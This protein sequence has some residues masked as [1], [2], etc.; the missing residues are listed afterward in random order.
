MTLPTASCDS[1]PQ[2][3]KYRGH[4]AGLDALRGSAVLGVVVCHAYNSTTDWTHWHGLAA[5][6][7]AITLLGHLGVHLFFVLSGFL[8]TGLLLDGRARGQLPGEGESSVRRASRFYGRRA[9]RILPAYLLMLAVLLSAH[10]VNGHFVLASLFFVVNLGRLVGAQL[11]QYSVVWSLAVEE[12][13]YLLWPWLAWRVSMRALVRVIVACLVLS[14]LLRLALAI[15]GAD[16]YYKTYTN[17]DYLMYGAL[18][19]T[20]LRTRQLHLGNIGRVTARLYAGGLAGVA[21]CGVLAALA[22]SGHFAGHAAWLLVLFVSVGRLPF[23]ALFVGLLLTSV[24]AHQQPERGLS[25]LPAARWTGNGLAFLGYISYG[26]YLVHTLVFRCYDAAVAGTGLGGFEHS[27]ALLTLR[28][29]LAGAASILLAWLSRS[30]LEAWFLRRTGPR[31]A[32]PRSA[33]RPDAMIKA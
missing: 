19:A 4:I 18:I 1:E 29:I 23:L 33:G 12:Q 15:H 9:R 24:L 13:F 7:I 21:V 28:A 14:P 16:T 32:G 5:G 3:L 31:S 22:A 25:G 17:L 11:A 26:L 2:P 20:T 30:T 10:Q 27:F 8:I 6:W